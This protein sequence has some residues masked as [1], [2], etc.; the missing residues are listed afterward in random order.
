[1]QRMTGSEVQ[2]AREA[3]GLERVDLA[4]L[5]GN[6]AATVRD[7]ER[8]KTFVPFKVQEQI[9]ELDAIT[10]R[11]VE[12]LVA[13]LREMPQAYAVV[14]RED[15]QPQTGDVARLGRRWWRV[16]AA[17]A[18]ARVPGT[19]IGTRVELDAMGHEA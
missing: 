11:A 19:R 9:G 15:E 7:W 10:G 5:L 3:L 16:V 14:Y 8:G 6:D 17:R 12:Q 13:D 18:A 4:R 1:M 2:C